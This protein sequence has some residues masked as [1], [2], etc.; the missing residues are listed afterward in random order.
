MKRGLIVAIDGPVAS[1]KG[2]MARVV[3]EKLHATY[4]DSGSMYRALGLYLLRQGLDTRNEIDV[5][6][7]LPVVQI[8]LH[9]SGVLLNGE[10]VS[11]EIRTPEVSSA[12]A[13]VSK[14]AQVHALLMDTRR[15]IAEQEVQDG[16][17]VVTEGRNEATHT[18]PYADI[19]IFL[20]ADVKV[21]AKRR[22]AQELV[23]GNDISL[24]EVEEQTR[25]R[26]K[27]DMEREHA[28]LTSEPEKYGYTI[29]DDSK[30][31]EEETEKI[32]IDIIQRRME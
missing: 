16:R 23:R 17:V 28:P 22:Y 6:N 12:A 3:A 29:V 15:K 13:N 9:E 31:T 14:F 20:T 25:F 26:D 1:G 27:Q 30:M 10:D 7:I 19:K 5:N 8:T 4:L 18:F 11:G 32:L 24:A 2:T 21:R